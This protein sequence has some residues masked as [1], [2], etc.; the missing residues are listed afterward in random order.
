LIHKVWSI[1]INFLR[2]HTRNI[3][4]PDS[5]LNISQLCYTQVPVSQK[6]W[7]FI[8]C[9][10]LQTMEKQQSCYCI[11]NTADDLTMFLTQFIHNVMNISL[12]SNEKLTCSPSFTLAII[13]ISLQ[14]PHKPPSHRILS[15]VHLVYLQPI[16]A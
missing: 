3:K 15:Q 7:F 10:Y 13:I 1:T 4:W 14:S 8:H 2:T 11:N 16:W 6:V 12:S 9:K 5:L